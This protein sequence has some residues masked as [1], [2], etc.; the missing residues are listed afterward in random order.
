M[1]AKKKKNGGGVPQG[2]YP[3]RFKRSILFSPVSAS[4]RKPSLRYARFYIWTQGDKRPVECRS[5]LAPLWVDSWVVV[6][7]LV[8]GSGSCVACTY[9]GRAILN[10]LTGESGWTHDFCLWGTLASAWRVLS[11][12]ATELF[13]ASLRVDLT[14]SPALEEEP[15]LLNSG[16]KI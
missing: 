12:I 1:N 6:V 13:F 3:K 4:R 11:I 9:H 15:R 2:K 8:W 5:S 14:I 10:F 7:F 16:E